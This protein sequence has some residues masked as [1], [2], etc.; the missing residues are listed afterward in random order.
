MGI[1][2]SRLFIGQYLM[3]LFSCLALKNVLDDGT[4]VIIHGRVFVWKFQYNENVCVNYQSV[5]VVSFCSLWSLGGVGSLQSV[6]GDE[7]EEL[8]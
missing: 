3:C 8:Q 5:A 6:E 1:E 4:C 7:D 2:N